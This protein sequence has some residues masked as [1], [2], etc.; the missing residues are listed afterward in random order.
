M[1]PWRRFIRGFQSA[2]FSWYGLD[3]SSE[4]WAGY[5][6]MFHSPPVAM[7]TTQLQHRGE[8]AATMLHLSP[9]TRRW[10]RAIN[11]CNA[12]LTAGMLNLHPMTQMNV[13]LTIW[14][15]V[16]AGFALIVGWLLVVIQLHLLLAGIDSKGISLHR[17]C[18]L[19]HNLM[20]CGALPS[21]YLHSMTSYIVLG[22]FDA[23]FL[24]AEFVLANSQPNVHYKKN[25][26][27]NIR[28]RAFK[29]EQ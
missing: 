28:T 6:I 9:C 25:I 29:F 4:C 22:L 10:H 18:W 17:H 16:H 8:S 26:L 27:L 20:R 15:K 2:D 13:Q 1:S 19:A 21:L 23:G 24:I 3:K 14:S 11:W 7:S 12:G 5:K